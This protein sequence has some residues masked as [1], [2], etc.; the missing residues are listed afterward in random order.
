VRVRVPVGLQRRGAWHVRQVGSLEA[1]VHGPTEH[2]HRR[3]C[4]PYQARAW[5]DGAHAPPRM[6]ALPT[7]ENK[8]FKKYD[9]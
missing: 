5:T 4:V 6:R 9:K 7:H 8:R 1:P 2:T 3:A